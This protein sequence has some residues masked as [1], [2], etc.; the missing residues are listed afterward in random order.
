MDK[1][2]SGVSW[3]YYWA[4]RFN[5]L[6]AE[7]DVQDEDRMLAI[8]NFDRQ[9]NW[10]RWANRHDYEV[11]DEEEETTDRPQE[12]PALNWRLALTAREDSGG[13]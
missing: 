5:W 4:D 2:D 11:Y 9:V 1:V 10:S 13:N 3:D 8:R 12:L 6:P 7:V